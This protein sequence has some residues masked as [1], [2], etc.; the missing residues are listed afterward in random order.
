[1]SAENRAGR[2]F[3]QIAQEAISRRED[4]EERMRREFYLRGEAVSLLRPLQEETKTLGVTR[5]SI[6][7]FKRVL[8]N[9]E[10]KGVR[11]TVSPWNQFDG[12]YQSNLDKARI[13]IDIGDEMSFI[14]PPHKYVMKQR[15]ENIPSS[16]M[17]DKIEDL[18][19]VLKEEARK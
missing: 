17:L 7:V 3:P 9:E 19:E 13:R 1:M 2:A 11:I 5:K 16:K 10:G 8:L 15:V 4:R 14:F 18:L 6:P 12:G